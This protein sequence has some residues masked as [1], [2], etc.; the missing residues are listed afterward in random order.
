MACLTVYVDANSKV[1]RM[2]QLAT[3]MFNV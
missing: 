3:P 1:H 2:R